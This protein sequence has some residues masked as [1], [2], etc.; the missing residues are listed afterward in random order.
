MKE[1]F[2]SVGYWLK[3]HKSSKKMKLDD[4]YEFMINEF[5]YDRMNLEK[6]RHTSTKY[7]FE[8]HDLKNKLEKYKDLEKEN[9]KL[10]E[11]L[12]KITGIVSQ[13]VT[14]NKNLQL[15]IKELVKAVD[16]LKSTRYL[17]VE[18]KPMKTPKAEPMKI[19]SGAKTSAIIKKVKE[20]N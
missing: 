7:L 18:E 6:E 4:I 9:Q 3:E 12:F 10:F 15:E 1:T 16:E 20:G 5:N 13:V 8:N 2:K 11:Y 14:E 17:V 19:K